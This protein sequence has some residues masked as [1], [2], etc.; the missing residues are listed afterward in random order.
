MAKDRLYYN[1]ARLLEFDAKVVLCEGPI[2]DESG[3]DLWRAKLSP[4]AFYPESG[5]QPSDRGT[6]DGKPLIDVTEDE[7]GDVVVIL[8]KQVSG[9]VHCIIDGA[10]RFDLM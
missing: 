8:D 7:A 5:G 6:V 1:D 2:K 10:R 3:R 9:V 4:N